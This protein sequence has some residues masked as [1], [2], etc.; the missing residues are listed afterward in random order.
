MLRAHI[1][2]GYPGEELV[3]PYG[4]FEDWSRLVR[5]ALVW[6]GE[7]DP[8]ATRAAIEAIDPER[9]ALAALMRAWRDHLGTRDWITAKDIL[10]R[11]N[12]LGASQ[13]FDP[14]GEL[15][16]ALTAL[17]PHHLGPKT[18]G[19][20]LMRYKDRIIDSM[21]IRVHAIKG[22]STRY[23]LEVIES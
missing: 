6:L 18:L 4:R 14:K 2:A 20:N 3:T 15:Q 12:G 5:G 13:N 21:R 16:D 23:R 8:C 17:V 1:V 7:P 22:E 19:R 11:A 10:D 9:D